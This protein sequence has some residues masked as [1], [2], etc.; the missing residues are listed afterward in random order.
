MS[1]HSLESIAA[2]VD[3]W[4]ERVN[5]RLDQICDDEPS[6][7]IAAV[8][9]NLFDAPAKRLR[10]LLVL[11]SAGAFE[12]LDARA[13][14][15]ACGVECL[16]T[17]TLIHDDVVDAA[18]TRRG[19]QTVH[20]LWSEGVAI[21][22]GDFMFALSAELVAHLERPSVVSKF[23][24]AI[25]QM[26]RAE[27]HA[28]DPNDGAAAAQADYLAKIE[29]K[30]AALIGL[31]ASAAADLA[32]RPP[33]EQEQMRRLGV[34]LGLAFQI[35]DDVLDLRGDPQVTGKPAG[36]DL[37]QAQLTLPILV[38]LGMAP[39]GEVARFY[40]RHKADPE[41]LALALDE[42]GRSGALD[43]AVGQARAL[44]DEACGLLDHL[45][46]NDC[47]SA[48]SDLAEFVV[49]RVR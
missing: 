10:P 46:D 8:L 17:A 20:T 32:D 14:E 19:R 13:V 33:A 24:D 21:L 42:I 15:L 45:P 28:P 12:R 49:D 9:Q 4:L 18:S 23:A 2:P 34:A 5:V 11:L 7:M 44:A 3:G 39:S 36:G 16:H 31:C 22:A 37:L 25:M 29:G 41:R 1:S 26:A 38:H 6:P 27:L 47:R 30:T 40:N 35:C 48:I 43:A